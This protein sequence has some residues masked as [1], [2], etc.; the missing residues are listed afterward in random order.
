[1]LAL[2]SKVPIFKTKTLSSPTLKTN[3]KKN[4]LAFCSIVDSLKVKYKS[5]LCHMCFQPSYYSRYVSKAKTL[6]ASVLMCFTSSSSA[7]S[8]PSSHSRGLAGR[9]LLILRCKV[10]STWSTAP[11]REANPGPY[12]SIISAS[13]DANPPGAGADGMLLLRIGKPP[14][15]PL[16]FV[17]F[18]LFFFPL[19]LWRSESY[20]RAEF[21]VPIFTSFYFLWLLGNR[22]WVNGPFILISSRCD[23]VETKWNEGA[24]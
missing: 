19:C 14:R 6:H 8:F 5:K 15:C 17:F 18:H 11:Q 13:S 7:F 9:A 21:I 24:G 4:F 2:C 1:M 16:K 12:C 20:E 23:A 3:L 10:W 22:F